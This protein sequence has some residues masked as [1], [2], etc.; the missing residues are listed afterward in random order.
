M[1]I[2][3][4]AR[5]KKLSNYYLMDMVSLEIVILAWAGFAAV[6]YLLIGLFSRA[7][8]LESRDLVIFLPVVNI[9]VFILVLIIITEE[10]LL[11]RRYP[12]PN[13]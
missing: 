10:W 8:H 13:D 11:N 9:V 7:W 1:Y 6:D 3:A 4:S 2:F 12:D 5:M